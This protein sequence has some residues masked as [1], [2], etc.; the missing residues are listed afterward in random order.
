[1]RGWGWFKNECEEEKG[2]ESRG[3]FTD[4]DLEMPVVQYLYKTRI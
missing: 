4:E 2:M 3:I 1:M